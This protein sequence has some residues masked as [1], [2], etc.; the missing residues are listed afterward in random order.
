MCVW[1]YFNIQWWF[2][3]QNQHPNH[4]LSW[5]TSLQPNF[6]LTSGNCPIC[7]CCQVNYMLLFS[8]FSLHCSG[9]DTGKLKTRQMHNNMNRKGV[10]V[11]AEQQ[12]LSTKKSFQDASRKCFDPKHFAKV[13]RCGAHRMHSWAEDCGVHGGFLNWEMSGKWRD[14]LR[15]HSSHDSGWQDP[16]PI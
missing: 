8:F 13:N 11:I 16:T 1:L 14:L 6:H 3:R 12:E 5:L 4:G 9:A 10:P 15:A 7:I 2:L